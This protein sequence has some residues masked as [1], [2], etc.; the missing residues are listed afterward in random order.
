MLLIGADRISWCQSFKWQGV[1][2]NAGIKPTINWDLIEQK[3]FVSFNGVL[4]HCHTM[5]K[6]NLFV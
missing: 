5:D 1:F 3:C 4:G 6:L 2:F